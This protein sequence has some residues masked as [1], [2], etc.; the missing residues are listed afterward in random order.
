[1]RLYELVVILD[2]SL[3]EDAISDHL[4]RIGKTIVSQGGSTVSVDHW[5][6]RRF[7]YELADRWEGYYVVIQAQGEPAMVAELERT[8]LITDDVLRHKVIR[9]PENVASKILS[10][11]GSTPASEN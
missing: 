10:R 2:S 6:R 9:L 11:V 1:M 8:L 4:D 7:A 5:G 3:D